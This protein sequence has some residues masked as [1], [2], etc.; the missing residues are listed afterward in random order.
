MPF[1]NVICC[2]LTLKIPTRD[3]VRWTWNHCIKTPSLTFTLIAQLI[4]SSFFLVDRPWNS[5]G[6]TRIEQSDKLGVSEVKWV[7]EL[8]VSECLVFNSIVIVLELMW[9]V[10]YLF[11]ALFFLICNQVKDN[12]GAILSNVWVN[13]DGDFHLIRYC[14]DSPG[15]YLGLTRDSPWLFS[16]IIFLLFYYYF[17]Y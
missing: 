13:D 2:R 8:S 12:W 4:E 10:T 9:L 17:Y 15:N 3:V 7:S 14:W 11:S 16:P 6:Q 5:H 1:V